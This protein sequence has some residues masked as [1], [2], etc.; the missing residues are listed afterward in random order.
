MPPRGN[1]AFIAQGSTL[2]TALLDR[3]VSKK[4]GFSYFVSLGSKFDIDFA[5]MIDFLGV[6]YE[7]RP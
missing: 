1:I 5:D 7:T 3:A 2:A 4:V 6:R